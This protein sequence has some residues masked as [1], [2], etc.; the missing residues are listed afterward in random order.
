[1]SAGRAARGTSP[2]PDVRK[3]VTFAAPPALSTSTRPPRMATLMGLVP[4]L[5]TTSVSRSLPSGL[6]ANSETWPDPASTA[7]SVVPSAEHH[8]GGCAERQA[9]SA[10]LTYY[11]LIVVVGSANKE[12]AFRSAGFLR[13][14]RTRSPKATRPVRRA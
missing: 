2:E 1:M 12:V 13:T 4:P 5:G 14:F 10:R 3:P 7:S 8:P 6:T 9:E 11:L